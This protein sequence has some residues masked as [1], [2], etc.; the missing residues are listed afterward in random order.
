MINGDFMYY[1]PDDIFQKVD[2]ASMA[3]SLETRAPFMDFEVIEYAMSLPL[4][5]KIKNNQGKWILKQLLYQYVPKEIV[6][7]PK[8][9]FGVPIGDWLRGPLREWAESLINNDKLI[10]DG[11]LDI[12][13]VKYIWNEHLSKKRDRTSEIWNI[14]MFQA[15]LEYQ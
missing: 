1:L 11:Y 9:G 6:D 4:S 3:V 14:L 8:M 5:L 13:T 10:K 2:R 15:W 12:E 7:R